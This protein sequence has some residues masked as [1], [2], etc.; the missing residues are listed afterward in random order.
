[1]DEETFRLFSA[2]GFSKLPVGADVPPLGSEYSQD[3]KLMVSDK[4]SVAANHMTLYK[5]E[6]FPAHNV[7]DSRLESIAEGAVLEITGPKDDVKQF[8]SELDA[9]EET[10][11]MKKETREF[12]RLDGLGKIESPLYIL[13]NLEAIGDKDG[14]LVPIENTGFLGVYAGK[15]SYYAHLFEVEGQW[16]ARALVS[17]NHHFP[18]HDKNL[19]GIEVKLTKYDKLEAKLRIEKRLA[20]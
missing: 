17:E 13:E 18:F 1:M 10:Y 14:E 12:Y 9:L 4:Y 15:A 7:H 20:A 5:G 16:Y 2:S 3:L 8:Q 6:K 11:G 19:R